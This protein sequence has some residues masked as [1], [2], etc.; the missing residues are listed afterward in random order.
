MNATAAAIPRFGRPRAAAPASGNGCGFP[1]GPASPYSNKNR[2]MLTL[3]SI[4][5]PIIMVMMEEPP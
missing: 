1:L 4:P 3:S 2:R 5:M